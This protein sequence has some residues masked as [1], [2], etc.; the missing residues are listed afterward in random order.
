MVAPQKRLRGGPGAVI[1]LIRRSSPGKILR[2]TSDLKKQALELGAIGE[3]VK[4]RKTEIEKCG[5]IN[6]NRMDLE[7]SQGL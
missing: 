6:P 1:S 3:A 2:R 4:K 5:W 7:G